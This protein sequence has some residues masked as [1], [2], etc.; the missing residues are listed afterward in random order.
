MA[1]F[2]GTIS[3]ST[4]CRN[5]T[6]ASAMMNATV[7]RA[8]PLMPTAASGISSRCATAGSPMAPRPSEHTVMPSWAPA[9]MRETRSIARSVIRAEREPAAARGSIWVRRAAMRANSAPTKK[10]LPISSATAM[11][12]A[13][14]SSMGATL[15]RVVE[16]LDGQHE[17]VDAPPVEPGDVQP[18]DG[19]GR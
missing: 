5:T 3:P 1:M 14:V 16:V 12:M 19:G 9:I 6:T 8:A 11:R 15:L 10:A 17:P 18:R 4:M 2:F 13:V 7:C